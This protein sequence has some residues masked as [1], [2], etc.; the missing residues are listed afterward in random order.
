MFTNSPD[1][2][3]FI[4]SGRFTLF[5]GF[6]RESEIFFGRISDHSNSYG[7]LWLKLSRVRVYFLFCLVES[8]VLAPRVTLWL[9]LR[10]LYSGF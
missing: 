4:A 10:S 1:V 3:V 8:L 9:N 6:R 5:T 2:C 7:Y